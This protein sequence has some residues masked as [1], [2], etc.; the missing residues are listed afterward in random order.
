MEVQNHISLY[1]YSFQ[2]NKTPV[3]EWAICKGVSFFLA[4][5]QDVKNFSAISKKYFWKNNLF[6]LALSFC[7]YNEQSQKVKN[8][9]ACTQDWK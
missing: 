7:I 6:C 9:L 5:S 2:Y 8:I 4:V 3:N 1:H